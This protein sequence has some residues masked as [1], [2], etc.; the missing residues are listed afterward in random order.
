MSS[1]EINITPFSAA[2]SVKPPVTSV[3]GAFA[4]G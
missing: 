4:G 1:K 3:S 2:N